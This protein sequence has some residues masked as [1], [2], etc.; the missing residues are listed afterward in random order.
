[1]KARGWT[2]VNL[3]SNNPGFTLPSNIGKLGDIWELNL[4]N[5]SLHGALCPVQQN[6][7]LK[8]ESH[9][10]PPLPETLRL[11]APLAPTLEMLHLGSNELGGTITDD[12]AA[13]TKLTD[14]DLSDMNLE[15]ESKCMPRH[16]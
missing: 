2:K 9:A 13:F 8:C 11:L 15:G 10:G 14:L 1:M 16:T 4:S 12:I 7:Q 5:S 6:S 3:S